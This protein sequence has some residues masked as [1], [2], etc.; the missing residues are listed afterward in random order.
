MK[1]EKI[2]K[3]SKSGKPFLLRPLK[4]S[5]QDK[6]GQKG[7]LNDFLI[8]NKIGNTNTKLEKNI[9]IDSFMNKEIK[10]KAMIY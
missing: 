8:D 9:F 10:N 5:L 7:Q 3:R 1:N 4:T 2:I 6:S